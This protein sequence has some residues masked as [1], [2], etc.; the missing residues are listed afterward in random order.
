MDSIC[1]NGSKVA[2]VGWQQ[3]QRGQYRV[4]CLFFPAAELEHLR[5]PI[6]SK[7]GLFGRAEGGGV[8]AGGL[9]KGT[10]GVDGV[11]GRCRD[12]DGRDSLGEDRGGSRVKMSDGRDKEKG[13]PQGY[14]G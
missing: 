3:D 2:H 14:V 12:C 10:L 11:V 4:C 9:C 5:V 6:R 1:S 7:A 8:V 13:L